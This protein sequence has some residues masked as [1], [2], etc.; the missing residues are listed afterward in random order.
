[1]L[2]SV[3]PVV[4]SA[5][6]IPEQTLTLTIA[7]LWSVA[8]FGTVLVLACGALWLLKN[9][10]LTSRSATRDRRPRTLGFPRP[11]RHAVAGAG[12]HAA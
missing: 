11:P 2:T 6:A 7:P 9:V 12:R 8:L 1:M 4:A 5:A 3:L 10:E